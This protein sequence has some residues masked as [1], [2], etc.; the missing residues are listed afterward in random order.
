[1][2]SPIH[3]IFKLV[4]TSSL[5]LFSDCVNKSIEFFKTVAKEGFVLI[6]YNGT[7]SCT[8]DFPLMLLPKV[9]GL[10]LE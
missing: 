8:L 3:D 10:I 4:L 5:Y 1:M 2:S 6:A 9:Q 7:S